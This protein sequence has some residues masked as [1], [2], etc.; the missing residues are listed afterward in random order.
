[1]CPVSAYKE[2]VR[3]IPALSDAPAFVAPQGADLRPGT[4]N[5]FEKNLKLAI[6]KVGLD[7]SY[8]SSHSMIR[9]AHLVRFKLECPLS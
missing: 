5:L 8:F 2:M 7:P 3:K 1:M 9:E 6:A 4:Y